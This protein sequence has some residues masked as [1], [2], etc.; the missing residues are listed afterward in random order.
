M[1]V[2]STPPDLEMG[3]I[4][5]WIRGHTIEKAAQEISKSPPPSH[6]NPQGPQPL[7]FYDSASIS[8]SRDVKTTSTAHQSRCDDSYSGQCS[9]GG[10]QDP[11][12]AAQDYQQ[13]H[14]VVLRS[15][16]EQAPSNVATANNQRGVDRP[17]PGEVGSG[18]SASAA[19]SVR[20]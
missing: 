15:A 17:P 14:Q 11:S 4:G 3:I 5:A 13:P 20:K 18:A 10:A 16:L 8:S 12:S 2:L 9:G 7:R 6:D 19:G 1:Q